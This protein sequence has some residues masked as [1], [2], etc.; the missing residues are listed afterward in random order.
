MEP[1]SNDIKFK[2]TKDKT[3][4]SQMPPGSH[5]KIPPGNPV[6]KNI[7]KT[8]LKRLNNRLRIKNSLKPPSKKK[9]INI[10]PGTSIITCTNRPNFYN[11]IIENYMRQEHGPK[12]LIIILNSNS[13]NLK[14][15]M[16]KVKKHDNIRVFQLGQNTTLGSCLNFAV[17]KSNFDII[18]K[19]DDDDYYGPKYL[20]EA[21]NAFQT[22]G[23]KVLG[24]A[25]TYVYFVSSKTLA[26]RSP[27]GENRYVSF[28]NGS[29]LI[30]KK[31]IFN[32]VKFRNL[33]VAE[34]VAFCRDCI[35]KGYQLYSTSK[36]NHVYIRYPKKQNHTWK[37]NDHE[38]MNRYCKVIEKTDDYIGYANSN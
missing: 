26:L 34:D 33:S 6:N 24:K 36:L 29:T 21:V 38:F 4:L 30:F 32:R 5:V 15:W 9:N 11:N 28:A 18:A 2:V 19:F 3:I 7:N 10:G 27:A 8:V 13:I 12:E 1:R 31:E 23:A 16:N 25:A 37:I 20:S 17:T 14:E 35:Y 22:T